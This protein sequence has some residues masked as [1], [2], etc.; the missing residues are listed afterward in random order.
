MQESMLKL[1]RDQNEQ[2]SNMRVEQEK[3]HVTLKEGLLQQESNLHDELRK[4][5]D[6]VTKELSNIRIDQR[7]NMISL[8]SE[9]EKAM[10]KLHAEHNKSLAEVLDRQ[11]KV[12]VHTTELAN[13]QLHAVSV[14]NEEAKSANDHV[15]A[16]LKASKAINEQDKTAG[17]VANEQARTV[18]QV[19]VSASLNTKAANEQA[20]AAHEQMKAAAS[21]TLENTK[22]AN[23]QAKVTRDE[24]QIA[25]QTN[26]VANEQVKAAQEQ[27]KAAAD[28]V[29]EQTKSLK[30]EQPR[31]GAQSEH[32][33]TRELKSPVIQSHVVQ[34]AQPVATTSSL[35]KS[36]LEVEMKNSP[37]AIN[38][39]H[40]AEQ[41]NM[42]DQDQERPTFSALDGE[43]ERV[44]TMAIPEGKITEMDSDA[45]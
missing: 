23:E 2:F 34:T 29:A 22:A 13:E 6:Q 1:M 17:E 43:A 5:N 16:A 36:K 8:Q 27:V 15:V 10:D 3:N 42:M 28:V 37:S 26:K 32:G 14:M 20:K 39:N 4:N 35:P 40:N 38:L 44:T 12:L 21:A 18:N 45:H 11:N 24:L 31:F 19:A 7:E 33:P 25:M 30:E 41:P 9:Q